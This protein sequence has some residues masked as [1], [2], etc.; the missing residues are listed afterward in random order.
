MARAHEG[1]LAMHVRAKAL[2]EASDVDHLTD[3]IRVAEPIHH[4]LSHDAVNTAYRNA[5]N[6][7]RL[8]ILID[9]L[10]EIGSGARRR[11]FL[12]WLVQ[13]ETH[14]HFLIASPTFADWENVT[15]FSGPGGGARADFGL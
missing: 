12:A 5:A 11:D 8:V 2:C 9:E 7:G 6:R 15:R 3:V 13:S 4:S 1:W 14:V 10:D